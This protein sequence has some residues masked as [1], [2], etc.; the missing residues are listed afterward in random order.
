MKDKN[1]DREELFSKEYDQCP[2]CGSKDRF[3]EGLAKELKDRGLA[4]ENWTFGL[5]SKQGIVVDEAMGARVPIGSLVPGYEFITD[6]CKDCGCVYARYVK[7]RKARI[8]LPTANVGQDRL[9][10][11]T[12]NLRRN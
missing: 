3:F 9:P 2:A 4:R 10:I 7:E 6:I 11:K 8:S 5:D 12:S 1:K